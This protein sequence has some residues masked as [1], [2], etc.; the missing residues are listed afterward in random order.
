MSVEVITYKKKILIYKYQK[1][2]QRKI[3]KNNRLYKSNQ[4]PLGFGLGLGFQIGFGI[5]TGV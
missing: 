3:N 4:Q 2:S 5:Y 1:K